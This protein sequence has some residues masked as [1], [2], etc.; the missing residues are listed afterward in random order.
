MLRGS[1]PY[2]IIASAL[3]FKGKLDNYNLR[4]QSFISE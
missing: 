4:L 1:L 2:L 3:L